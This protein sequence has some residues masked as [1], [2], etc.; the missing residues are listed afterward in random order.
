MALSAKA[1][2]LSRWHQRQ[3]QQWTNIGRVAIR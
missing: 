1:L 3:W 2:P